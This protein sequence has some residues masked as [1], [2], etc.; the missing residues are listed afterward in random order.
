[1]AL[2]FGFEKIQM[3]KILIELIQSD[4]LQARIDLTQGVSCL[5]FNL[6]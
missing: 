1:M 2:A 5:P 6:R 3:Q 4:Q